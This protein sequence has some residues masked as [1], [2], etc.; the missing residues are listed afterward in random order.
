MQLL[1]TGWM[2]WD[3]IERARVAFSNQHNTHISSCRLCETD[4]D[5]H[6]LSYGEAQQASP[7]QQTLP[8]S[9]FPQQQQ[10]QEQEQE[11][12]PEPTTTTK[13]LEQ[14]DKD[15][16]EIGSK[17]THSTHKETLQINSHNRRVI[18]YKILFNFY[19]TVYHQYGFTFLTL[20][21]LKPMVWK[22]ST[23]KVTFMKELSTEQR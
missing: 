3:S 11:Q 14:D 22:K 1:L 6:S 7:Q 17:A 5:T 12:E 23:E 20:S 10:E 21:I 18:T 19:I 13:T 8:T 16:L 15:V 4:S 9:H 2:L